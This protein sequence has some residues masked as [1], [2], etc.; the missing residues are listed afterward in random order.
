MS[1]KVAAMELVGVLKRLEHLYHQIDVEA[2]VALDKE[3]EQIMKETIALFHYKAYL[4]CL[5]GEDCTQDEELINDN[6]QVLNKIA[7]KRWS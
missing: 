7:E 3:Q 6:R 4:R 5:I 2:A 1:Q